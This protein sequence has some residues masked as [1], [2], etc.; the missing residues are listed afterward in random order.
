MKKVFLIICLI[1]SLANI[2]IAMMFGFSHSLY[3]HDVSDCM[4]TPL[5]W[6]GSNILLW[7]RNDELGFYGTTFGVWLCVV[8]VGLILSQKKKSPFWAIMLIPFFSLSS[9]L[10]TYICNWS[11]GVV[12]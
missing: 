5:N 2:A 12:N 7:D 11:F 8:G 1:A 3:V 9:L 4:L 10:L 6:I